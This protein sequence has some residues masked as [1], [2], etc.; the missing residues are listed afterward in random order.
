MLAKI[1]QY[2][3]A[4]PALLSTQLSKL[5]GNVTAE[6]AAIRLATMPAAGKVVRV[7][8]NTPP[9]Q[10]P[11]EP[12]QFIIADNTNGN[13]VVNIAAP[14]LDLIGQPLPI[15]IKATSANVVKIAIAPP[16]FG[17]TQGLVF[18][19]PFINIAAASLHI[20]MTDGQDWWAT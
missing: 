16:K 5:E 13:V 8:P 7:D 14:R 12:G 6:T 4:K 20:F 2:I 1:R 19:S 17:G 18:G 9:G 15:A 11:Y 10:K 3:T